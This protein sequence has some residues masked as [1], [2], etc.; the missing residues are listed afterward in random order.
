MAVF[1]VTI[2]VSLSG[3]ATIDG[4]YLDTDGNALIFNGKTMTLGGVEGTFKIKQKSIVFYGEGQDEKELT[5]KKDGGKIT[6]GGVDYNLQ[7]GKAT[8][9]PTPAPAE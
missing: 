8:A 7:G 1:I 4:T 3:C 5:Y 6:L 2:I 9:E